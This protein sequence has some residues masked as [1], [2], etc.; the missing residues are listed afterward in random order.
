MRTGSSGSAGS[1]DVLRRTTAGTQG[2]SQR[3]RPA[4]RRTEPLVYI[5]IGTVILI[6]I[7]I[8]LLT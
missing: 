3:A 8:L 5:G 1:S 2:G 7:L 4:P 6:I